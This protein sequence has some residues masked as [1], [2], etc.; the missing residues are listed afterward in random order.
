MPV[1]L[2][3]TGHRSLTQLDQVRRDVN[4]AIDRALEAGPAGA[5][6][7]PPTTLTVVSALAEGADRLVVQEC[8]RRPGTTLLAILPLPIEEYEKDFATSD[9]RRE[10]TELLAA[11]ATVEIAEPMPT[12]EHAYER[13][14]QLMVEHS[15]AVIAIWDGQP[16]AGRGGPADIVAY[17]EARRVPIFRVDIR[18]DQR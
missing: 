8:F 7:Q 18:P 10:F 16:A 15:D 3:V 1:R 14:G 13:A 9:S 5:P 6:P 2:G 11:A 17:A 4:L 12:R